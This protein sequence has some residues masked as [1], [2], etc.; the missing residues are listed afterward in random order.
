[1]SNQYLTPEVQQSI[2]YQLMNT[3]FCEFPTPHFHVTP[4]FPDDIYA[5]MLEFLPN[6]DDYNG[7]YALKRVSNPHNKPDTRFVFSLKTDLVRLEEEKRVFWQEFA[8]FLHG[9]E[10]LM[11]IVQKCA[12]II[13]R[14]HGQD[15]Y[16]KYTMTPLAELF[17]DIEGYQIGPHT[18]SRSRL[19]NC[20]FYLPEDDTRPQL[21]TSFYVQK[22]S[23]MQL[24]L[25]QH[26]EFEHF[27]RAFT[28]PYVPNSM[29][30]FVR[31]DSSLHG[32][33]PLTEPGYKR[34]SMAYMLMLNAR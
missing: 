5:R 23:S 33:E 1:M 27:T 19:L 12:P 9:T 28:A 8:D 7:I 20:F 2:F 25:E 13:L 22:D 26:H 16:Q 10:F 6:D 15:F 3:P 21:G 24:N 34:N 18:D 30:V 31:T 32:V 29:A 17:R 4:I 14:Q 11:R